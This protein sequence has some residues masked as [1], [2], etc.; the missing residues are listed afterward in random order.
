M[1]KAKLW[2]PQKPEWLLEELTK[3]AAG[4]EEVEYFFVQFRYPSGATSSLESMRVEGT[5][6]PFTPRKGKVSP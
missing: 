1:K 3:L 4:A 2:R 6:D 5:K